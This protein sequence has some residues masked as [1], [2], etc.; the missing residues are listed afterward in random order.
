MDLIAIL[1][2][3]AIAFFFV[4]GVPWMA[5]AARREAR[6]LRVETGALVLRVNQLFG[7]IERLR[8]APQP[9]AAEPVAEPRKPETLD[10]A[11]AR[12]RQ[13]RE[14]AKA[15]EVQPQ[16]DEAAASDAPAADEPASDD[17][18]FASPWTR[19]ASIDP[20]ASATQVEP[21]KDFEEV[22]GTRWAIWVGGVALALGSLFLV[23]YTIEAGLLGP[24]ARLTLGLLFSTLL[25]VAGE[26]LRRGIVLPR[27]AGTT[28]PVEH[29]P[30]ALTAAGTVGLFAVVYAAH[31][32]YGFIPQAAALVLLGLIGMAAMA[33]SVV[34]GQALAGLGLVGSYATPLLIG[35]E[36]ANRWPLVVFL[37]V[38]TAAGLATQHRLRTLWLGWA[39]MAC[40][41]AW[42]FLL[43]AAQRP[44][45]AAELTFILDALVLF[46]GAL[47]VVSRPRYALTNLG[48]PLP[49]V[50]MS[51]LLAAIGLSFVS[52]ATDPTLHAMTAVTAIVLTACA[53]VKDGRAGV[54]IVAAGLLALGM[55]LTWPSEA[56]KL[57][58]YARVIA[59][60]LVIITDAPRA[61]TVLLAFALLSALSL[62]LAPLALVLRRIVPT[63]PHPRPVLAALV[64][65]GGLSAS[66]LLF[67][68][69][70]RAGGL[71]Q[72][73]AGAALVATLVVVLAW[74]TRHLLLRSIK[75][76]AE[77][78][79]R[80]D[81]RLAAGGYGAGAALALGLAIALA[82][83]GL[84]MAVGFAVAAA[85]VAYLNDRQ[86]LP[87][88]RRVSATFATTALL[89]A[90]LSPVWQKEGAWPV[91]NTYILAYALPAALLAATAYVL[92]GRKQDRTVRTTMVAAGLMAA[93]YLLY[94]IRH[95]FHGAD[96]VDDFAFGLGE[97]GLYAAAALAAAWLLFAIRERIS[98]ADAE[99]LTRLLKTLNM[100][101][102]TLVLLLVLV[103][104]N[105]WLGT[106]I[107]GL[108]VLDST[109]VGF[110]V[111]GVLMGAL[112]YLGRT[113]SGWMSPRLTQANRNLAIALGYLYALAQTRIA[114][115]GMDRFARAYTGQGEQ[116]AYSAVTLA[117]GVLLLVIGFRLGSRPTRMASA[118]FVTLA[119]LKV[120]VVD[121][122]EL[123]GLYRAL[124]FIGL[125]VV[126]IGIGLAYQRL[127]F[128]RKGKDEAPATA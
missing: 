4:V 112:A 18:P 54:S 124:S 107:S 113:R 103:A 105:P 64:L 2:G 72:N 26:G 86:P 11:L 52:H 5:I 25:L 62:A 41:A 104:A 3:L 19:A 73:L 47:L 91:L 34:H 93:L 10:E 111:P 42:S 102:I 36:S 120:F 116:Y 123:Q 90:L 51:G 6:A 115:V 21:K 92:G 14:A 31:A 67:A 23:R 117:F 80:R 32:L 74:L 96:L 43:I 118:L 82:L 110:A 16:M 65:T 66:I 53:V 46:A 50:A 122:A 95:A 119:I 9:A 13:T 44:P 71:A 98:A 8:T 7:E 63:T 48:D 114:F 58:V 89:R 33:A 55:I 99:G 79:E 76:S 30:L 29:A 77:M 56:G 20:P 125:G 15:S 85:G 45:A 121:L 24:A 17:R 83:P 100:I 108:P 39:I 78:A 69:A 27:V 84:W 127:L 126:L 81:L 59:G 28:L 38:V 35:G 49:V 94:T 60:A 106:R 70:L 109:F 37:L 97:S 12:I 88:L 68:W 101:G 57:P 22:I 1:A 87:M 40:V 75:P 128:D 61:P